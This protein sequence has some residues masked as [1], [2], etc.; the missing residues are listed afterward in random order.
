MS[1]LNTNTKHKQSIVEFVCGHRNSIIKGNRQAYY[2]RHDPE[3]IK[4][5]Y[6]K[7]NFAREV[8]RSEV[9]KLR[10]QL[11]NEQSKR[12]VNESRIERVEKES[13]NTRELLKAMLEKKQ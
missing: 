4:A 3:L 8:P 13:E 10:Q 7:C 11:E 9:T 6:E 1:S 2:D 5:A 12:A